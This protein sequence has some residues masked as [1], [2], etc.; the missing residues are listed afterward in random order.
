QRRQVCGGDAAPTRPLPHGRVC[1]GCKLLRASGGEG[2]GEGE[3]SISNLRP[4]FLARP[5]TPSLSPAGSIEV[6][7]L[8]T[9]RPRGRGRVGSAPRPALEADILPRPCSHTRLSDLRLGRAEREDRNPPG[10]RG[11]KARVI[12]ELPQQPFAPLRIGCAAEQQ[13]RIEAGDR[14]E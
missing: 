9:L 2:R 5:L 10:A 6:R 8:V 3:G 4:L 12:A 14:F 13:V 1:Q 11:V 7:W